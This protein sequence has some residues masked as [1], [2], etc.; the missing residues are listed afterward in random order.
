[1][2]ASI[3]NGSAV[4]I[5]KNILRFKDG[6]ELASTDV[7]N[8]AGLT[9]NVQDQLDA[10][11]D[12]SVLAQPNGVA[13]LDSGGKVPVSQL[14]N[15]IM[16]Y[17]GTWA[18]STNTPTL[19]DGTGNAGDVYIASDAGTVNFGAGPISFV[20]GDWVVYS[21]SVWQKSSNSNSVVSV[22]GFTGVVTLTTA[23]ISENTNLYFTD[24]RAQDAVGTILANS[25][26]VS[27]SYNDI[28][29]SI[30]A[31]I[32]AGSLTNN[33]ISGA[34][35]IA[36]SK[37]ALSNS[38]VNADINASAA[39]S[40]SKLAALTTGRALQSNAST[41]SIEVSSVTNTELGYLSGVTS[42]IQTQLNSALL[43]PMTAKGDLIAGGVSGIT[44]RLPVGTNGQVL[45]ANS[46]ASVGVNWTSATRVSFSVNTSTTSASTSAPFIFTNVVD[47]TGSGYNV[48]TGI[49]TAPVAG[50][51]MFAAG[52]NA[53]GAFQLNILKNGSVLVSGTNGAA[54]VPSTVSN[55]L[56][57]AANDTIQVR[58]NVPAA[59]AGGAALTYF[60]GF[61]VSGVY[62]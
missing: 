49:F 29:P 22:N 27:L 55:A 23:D 41:G 25:T 35:G 26:N 50:Y 15:S 20:A 9:S 12:T 45:V 59:A 7:A 3:F 60:S 13:T 46:G 48:S 17:L 52:V 5:L 53:G 37:L 40:V 8:L 31:A 16:E 19:A 34:A 54:S 28:T 44:T 10:K 58:P 36:Y 39:I 51:Y 4:K 33:E 62:T 11:V 2:A 57:L 56:L 30:T 43:N 14:P 42:N 24:E 38:I 47:N 21:G 32:V 18:A 61:L 6:A 1:M